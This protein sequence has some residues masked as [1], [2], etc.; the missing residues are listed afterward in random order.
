MAAL[1]GL[2]TLHAASRGRAVAAPIV[3]AQALLG[4]SDAQLTRKVYTH[5]AVADLRAA[6]EGV[7]G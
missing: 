1:V 3:H 6:V 4:H 5:L 7:A 2:R